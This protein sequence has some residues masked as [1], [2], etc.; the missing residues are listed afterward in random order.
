MA[1]KLAADDPNLIAM[2]VDHLKSRGLFDEFRR[3]CL[4]DVD[5]KPAYQNLRQRVDNFVSNHL[6][7][8]EWN[9]SLNKNQLRNE[10]R[11]RVCNFSFRA[12]D[13]GADWIR[14]WKG[15]L[16]SKGTLYLSGMLES[17]VDR[18]I[19]Q[20]VDPKLYHIFKPQIEK[21]VHEF[22]ATEMKEDV[23]PN[24]PPE[25]EKQELS[26]SASGTP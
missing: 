3:D 25:P 22:M 23:V 17:G 6:A 13:W 15:R 2:I 8:H 14:L 10:L 20:V 18:I 5:T 26:A 1:K 21:A 4:A 12:H 19:S 16:W 9:P 24:P 11:Q 7:N